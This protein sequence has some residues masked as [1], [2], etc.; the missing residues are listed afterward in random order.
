MDKFFLVQTERTAVP[1]LG[2]LIQDHLG[3]L[4]TAAEVLVQH[5]GEVVYHASADTSARHIADGERRFDFASITKLFTTSAIMR[6]VDKGQIGLDQPIAEIIPEI[7][8]TRKIGPFEEPVTGRIR[9]YDY[10]QEEVDAG[11]ITIRHLLA[12]ISGL[13]AWKPL[14]R[15]ESSGAAWQQIFQTTWAYPIGAQIVYSDIGFI[16]LGEAIARTMGTR[17]DEA[18]DQLVLQPIGATHTG[19]RPDAQVATVPTEWCAW[20]QRRI[21]GEVHDEN[22]ARLE[23]I[24]GHAGLFGTAS[25]LLRLADAS[26]LSQV[27]PSKE[28]LLSPSTAQEMLREHANDG[29]QRRALGWAL[30]LPDSSCGPRWSAASYG[31]TGFTGTSLWIDP[32][33]S[34]I[35][36]LLTNRVFF[37]RENAKAIHRF[38]LQVH[39][40]IGAAFE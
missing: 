30:H 28:R 23:G 1:E 38:R 4:F 33:N 34:L 40:A 16:L 15:T 21:H 5:R 13:P 27:A 36:V 7:G 12:H 19:F 11:V 24:S 20:R 37:G 31:H 17:L 32:E 26:L 39:T 25:D 14:Y 22:A 10:P 9:S 29:D 3:S 18:I 35:C 8:G 6:L 2:P